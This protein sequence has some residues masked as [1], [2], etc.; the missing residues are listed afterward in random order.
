M[1]NKSEDHCRY[2]LKLFM[3]SDDLKINFQILEFIFCNENDF[4]LIWKQ[5]LYQTNLI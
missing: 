3:N 1:Q 2:T 4:K 5:T